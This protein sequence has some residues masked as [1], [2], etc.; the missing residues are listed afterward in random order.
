[1]LHTKIESITRTFSA[2]TRR[3]LNKYAEEIDQ[4]KTYA[5]I[6]DRIKS[7]TRDALA[8]L[9]FVASE[10]CSVA[11]HVSD[12]N[13]QGNILC[14]DMGMKYEADMEKLAKVL[15]DRMQH[16]TVTEPVFKTN[17]AKAALNAGIVTEAELAKCVM[18]APTI[19]IR[20]RH[21][22]DNLTPKGIESG[23]ARVTPLKL[24]KGV[25]VKRG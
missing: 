17:K 5:D 22:A 3:L 18:A 2:A 14:F 25:K 10:P 19:A 16:V 12:N 1:M 4:A 24:A 11:Y 15:G 21:S 20:V 9:F 23:E 6:A 13:Q 7:D 8:D